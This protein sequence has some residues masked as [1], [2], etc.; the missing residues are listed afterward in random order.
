MKEGTEPKGDEETNDAPDHDDHGTNNDGGDAG[1]SGGEDDDEE[2][3]SSED[4]DDDEEEQQ[5]RGPSLAEIRAHKMRRNQ[6]MLESLGLGDGRGLLGGE[7]GNSAAAAALARAKSKARESKQ[8]KA[9][10][11]RRGMLLPPSSPLSAR[12]EGRR[13]GGSFAPASSASSSELEEERLYAKYPHRGSQIRKLLGLLR[14]NSHSPPAS[15]GG[16]RGGGEHGAPAPIFVTGPPGTGKT[17]VVFDVLRALANSSGDGVAWACADCAHLDVPALGEATRALRGQLWDS[18]VK[19]Q[20][21]RAGFGDHTGT[22]DP[23]H[24]SDNRK[25]G[26]GEAPASP[27]NDENRNRREGE[28]PNAPRASTTPAKQGIAPRS[29]RKRTP[30]ARGAD[31]SSNLAHASQSSAAARFARDLVGL[32]ASV[33]SLGGG[34]RPPSSAV[35]VLDRADRLL[36]LPRVGQL[37]QPN[38][39]AQL[40]AIPRTVGLRLTVVAIT[41]SRLLEHSRT[42]LGTSNFRTRIALVR[43][44]PRPHDGISFL[45]PLCARRHQPAGIDDCRHHP[46]HLHSIPRL[47]HQG[48]AQGCASF[49]NSL[50]S[51][52]S[53]ICPTLTLSHFSPSTRCCNRTTCKRS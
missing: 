31:F 25:D 2:G 14:P 11:R 37:E 38:L 53:S 32:F 9:G 23:D 21:H 27:R 43:E 15:D 34:N 1:A 39:L 13:P 50:T 41:A 35:I 52:F 17:G 28:T 6:A 48:H 4:E 12:D 49:T 3:S 46:A 29:G 7:E 20:Q 19:Q 44:H 42:S 33:R 5:R 36:S 22:L 51:L 45:S 24:D 26:G 30:P 10:H 16:A 47:Q 8:K 18:L 40:L